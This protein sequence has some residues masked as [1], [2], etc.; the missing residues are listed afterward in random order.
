M[1]RSRIRVTEFSFR[2]E[3]PENR[4]VGGPWLEEFNLS[5]RVF[6]TGLP[7]R[8]RFSPLGGLVT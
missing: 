3:S 7:M 5:R 6:W 8:F 1:S 4:N 2:R